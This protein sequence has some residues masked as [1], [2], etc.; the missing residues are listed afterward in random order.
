MKS[1]W[2]SV[3]FILIFWAMFV[4]AFEFPDEQSHFVSVDY[5]VQNGRMPAGDDKDVNTEIA[6][7]ESIVGTLRDYRGINRYTYHPENKLLF[8]GNIYGPQEET[9]LRLNTVS[10]RGLY[11]FKEG[12]RYPIFYYWYSAIAYR[13]VGQQSVFDRLFAARLATV[14]LGVFTIITAYKIGEEIFTHEYQAR[15]IAFLAV[16]QPM[17]TFV[18]SG[19]NSDVLHNLLFSLII[20]YCLRLIKHKPILETGIYLGVT[21]M[22]DFA[23]KPQAYVALPIILLAFII[24]AWYQKEII[25]SLKTLMVLLLIGVA[26]GLYVRDPRLIILFQTGKIPYLQ[27]IIHPNAPLFWDY[28][29]Y[30][31]DRLIHQNIV[32]YWGVFKWLGVVLPRPWWWVANRL[33]L[34]SIVGLLFG[35][36]KNFSR[37]QKYSISFLLLSSGLYIF[38]I[39]WFDWTFV[40][41]NAIQVA[42]Q[43]RYYFPM[44]VAHL[45]ILYAGLM[46]F[47]T[48]EKYRILVTK[49]LIVFFIG[50]QLAGIY[51]IAKSYYDLSSIHTLFIQASQYKPLFAKGIMWWIWGGLYLVG[52]G[53]IL[54]QTMR[55]KS[56]ASVR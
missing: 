3:F 11:H 5:Y 33:V 38:A 53:N 39:F 8:S 7:T 14:L 54:Y 30:S 32:W 12:A 49:I 28:V 45:T 10:D 16:L 17:M 31:L 47:F 18:S 27:T 40:R 24:R 9:I 55:A 23:T 46:G 13:L 1:I 35:Y 25:S 50:L 51:T 2:L 22:L 36:F 15:S 34:V 20:L 4:P 43:A 26:M 44:L 56:N 19:V 42:V 52:L 37:S 48:S 29:R 6:T 21:V 41:A